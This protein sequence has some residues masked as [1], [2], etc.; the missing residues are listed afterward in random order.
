MRTVVQVFGPTHLAVLGAVPLLAAVLAAIHRKIPRLGL[1]I[2]I[3][4]ALVLFLSWAAFYGGFV[5]HGEPLFPTHVP[6]ELC[7]IALWMVLIALLT[8]SPAL[9]DVAYYAAVAGASMALLT[10]NLVDPTW[11]QTTQFFA[12]HGL[13]VVA[14]L[15]LVWSG[16]SRPRPGSVLRAFVAINLIAVAVGIFDFVYK[17]DYMFLRTKPPTVSLLDVF[18]PWPWYI[19]VCEPVG[20]A[21]F[22]LLYL[23]FRVSGVGRKT[24]I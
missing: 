8:L 5:L 7:D 17:T 16:Q 19:V 22:L 24:R 1:A 12:D 18:G 14:A 4:L 15:Y 2:R 23:P 20:V 3:G 13:I 11:F 6:L 9:F 10:P 21:L